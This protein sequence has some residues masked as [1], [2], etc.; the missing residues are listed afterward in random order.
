MEWNFARRNEK[1][2]QSVT[3]LLPA[4]SCSRGYKHFCWQRQSTPAWRA[5]CQGNCTMK[6]MNTKEVFFFKPFL[7][8]RF[9]LPLYFYVASPS[10][11]TLTDSVW[12]RPSGLRVS[13][14]K[15]RGVHLIKTT[16][17]TTGLLCF[18]RAA[19]SLFFFT[20]YNYNETLPPQRAFIERIKRWHKSEARNDRVIMLCDTEA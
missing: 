8:F 19:N 5:A 11:Q 3:Y 10:L 16:V 9:E 14:V 18:V 17:I 1:S 7:A 12:L 6:K 15:L 13:F 2:Y 20:N 4:P